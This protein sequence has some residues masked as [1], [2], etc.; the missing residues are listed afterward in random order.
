MWNCILNFL[1]TRL[2]AALAPVLMGVIAAGFA[3]VAGRVPVLAP[4]LT[5]DNQVA[6]AGFVLALLMT[7]V[8]YLTTAR[9]WKYAAPVQRLLNVL[10]GRLGLK[11]VIEDG[12]IANVTA[13][14]AGE[15]KEEVL[16]IPGGQFNK[17]VAVK[18]ARAADGNEGRN[19]TDE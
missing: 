17:L 3:W 12:V 18:R 7:M 19:G 16:S 9:A 5:A 11:P 15:I 6:L 4:Y 1:A 13:A 8:N 2:G 10:A 14:T